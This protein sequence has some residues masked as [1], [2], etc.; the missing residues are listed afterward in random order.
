MKA[1]T[2]FL[3]LGRCLFTADELELEFR[4]ERMVQIDN[5]ILSL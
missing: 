4:A 2:V 3:S 1:G 5:H